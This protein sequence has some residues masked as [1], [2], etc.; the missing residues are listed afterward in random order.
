M[1]NERNAMAEAKI[2]TYDSLESALRDISRLDRFSDVAI[3][4][5]DYESKDPPYA[6]IC[7]RHPVLEDGYLNENEDWWGGFS[8]VDVIWRFKDNVFPM[9]GQFHR[10]LQTALPRS[11]D[12]TTGS[13]VSVWDKLA[14][15]SENG[16]DDH[17]MVLK[18]PLLLVGRCE[19]TREPIGMV[20]I[21]HTAPSE[22]VRDTARLV[23]ALAT[24]M[25]T[26][27]AG[28]TNS[29]EVRFDRKTGDATSVVV[30]DSHIPSEWK[31]VIENITLKD[32]MEG[33]DG[34]SQVNAMRIFR[35]TSP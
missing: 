18:L 31:D 29:Q 27:L 24:A 32:I 11:T 16:M 10:H 3:V 9:G 2:K 17:Q 4:A 6:I 23:F 19:A 21:T 7:D 20:R 34:S 35:A 22:S 8:Q 30:L 15:Y 26:D 13:S 14:K 25:E 28:K 5:L 12:D 33:G 1:T